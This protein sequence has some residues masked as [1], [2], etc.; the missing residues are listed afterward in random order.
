MAHGDDGSDRSAMYG[1]QPCMFTPKSNQDQEASQADIV[2]E[3][4][5]LRQVVS[6][7]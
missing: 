4:E 5:S 1:I 2:K 6:E 7:W 3:P